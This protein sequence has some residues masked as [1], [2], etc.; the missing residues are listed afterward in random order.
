MIL[1]LL[2]GFP[3][4]EHDIRGHIPG[5]FQV[6]L[7]ERLY[8]LPLCGT[9]DMEIG[10]PTHTIQ[11]QMHQYDQHIWHVLSDLY[12]IDSYLTTKYYNGNHACVDLPKSLTAKGTKH[13]SLHESHTRECVQF[14]EIEFLNIYG[15]L[16]VSGIFTKELHNGDHLIGSRNAFMLPW[17]EK[18]TTSNICQYGGVEPDIIPITCLY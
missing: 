7:N 17:K 8:C 14:N 13:P 12:H 9:C 18:T 1:R 6:L 16:N 3:S 5:N 15:K 4:G 10:L 11:Q 2:L